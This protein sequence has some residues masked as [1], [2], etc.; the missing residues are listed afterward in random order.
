MDGDK[1]AEIFISLEAH[2]TDLKLFKNMF[3]AQQ[4]QIKVI[5]QM[6]QELRCQYIRLSHDQ[7]GLEH[8]IKGKI[9]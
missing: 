9:K 5:E 2:I 7:E 1:E 3:D 6:L 8:R 4:K